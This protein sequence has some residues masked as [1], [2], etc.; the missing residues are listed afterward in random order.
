MRKIFVAVFFIVFSLSINAQTNR[1]KVFFADKNGV[2]FNPQEYFDSK[3]I[4]RR[5]KQGISLYDI[6]DFPVREDYIA[7]VRERVHE[8]TTVSR[9]FNMVFV[10]ADY[11]QIQSLYNLP[12]V[13]DIEPVEMSAILASDEYDVSMTFDDEK[14]L[15]NQLI[16]MQGNLFIENNINGAGVRIAIFDG[17]FPNV[18]KSPVFEHIRANKRIVATYDFT[19]NKEFVYSYNSHGTMVLS[20]IAGKFDDKIMGLATESEFLLA[21]TEI[22]REPFSEEENWLAAVEWADKNGADII[23]SSL[24]YTAQRYFKSDM[25]GQ[26]SLVTRAG[27]LAARKGILVVNAMGNS[28][29][30]AWKILGAPADADSVLSIGGIDPE[31][32]YHQNF[33]SYGPTADNRRKPNV[34]AY[35]TAVVAGKSKIKQA[36][37]TSFATPLVTGFAACVLQKNPDLK[38]MELFSEIEK[39]ASLYPYFDYAHGYGLPQALYFTDNKIK[40][41]DESFKINID[42]GKLEIIINENYI[43]TLSES[44]NYLYY[45]FHNDDG[46]I[47]EYFLVNVSEN[48]IS[49]DV[50][51]IKETMLFTVFYKSYMKTEK[52]YN[53]SFGE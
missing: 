25:N 7:L 27:N 48:K 53:Y 41:A 18:D 29:S 19:K 45:K 51:D 22:N 32:G 12:F 6:T 21:R 38:A 17:G 11:K 34:S 1:Y 49:I 20:C 44:K 10:D 35:S 43:D 23:N 14:L 33:S 36:Q 50:D 9:W 31:T 16:S 26:K 40:N 8:I 52:L 37:G 2:E 47:Y 13:T 15:K 28:G 39:S 42:G 3:A 46:F 30:S 24:G 5:I 4:E